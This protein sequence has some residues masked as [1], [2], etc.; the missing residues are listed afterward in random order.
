MVSFMVFRM[1]N[2]FEHGKIPA[3]SAAVKAEFNN[4]K[5]RLFANALPTRADLFIFRHT[6]YINGRIKIVDVQNTKIPS[7]TE[8]NH[9]V[10]NF[11]KFN[12]FHMS[13]QTVHPN[14][15][16]NLTQDEY[17]RK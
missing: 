7:D 3:S 15:S 13:P 9:T 4:V 6:D 16:I 8:E 14:F 1:P 5:C 11:V 2:K 17:V 12:T 10:K